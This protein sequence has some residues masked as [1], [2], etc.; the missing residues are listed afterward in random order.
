[1]KDKVNLKGVISRNTL[2]L[3]D[4]LMI[5]GVLFTS[6]L[7]NIITSANGQP[8]DWLGF[9]A[10]ITGVICNVLI[11]KQNI[12]NYAFGLANVILYAI[13]AFVAKNY[14]NAALNLLYYVPMQFIGWYSWSNN[15]SETDERKV[16]SRRMSLKTFLIMLIVTVTLIF[17]LWL[18]LSKM[19]DSSPWL[20]S[21][22][23]ILSM[24]AMFMM[25]RTYAE[26]WYLW[27]VINCIQ[28]A[29]WVRNAANGIPYSGMMIIMWAFFLLN[30]INGL[31]IWL[32]EA[33]R[34][35]AE[36]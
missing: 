31:R 29:M 2:N 21:I 25:I 36:L 34:E 20:D 27:I 11:A 8:F 13:I 3:F 30:S 1:M 7:Y 33:K 5:G 9:F 19:K 23:T 32:K 16:Q 26:Q 6:L 12:L 24:V 17:A 14:G 10:A 18:I 28:I 22:S 4:Y 35:K 15:R